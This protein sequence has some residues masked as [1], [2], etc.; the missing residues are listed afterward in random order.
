MA[1]ESASAPDG[2]EQSQLSALL[3]E[4]NRLNAA[5]LELFLRKC[6]SPRILPVL[7]HTMT[8]A[9]RMMR[10]KPYDILLLDLTLP[11][12]SG[13]ET[14]R[15]ARQGAPNA[16]IVVLTGLDDDNLASEAIKA[17]AQD[18]IAKGSDM[19]IV[20]RAIRY[21]AERSKAQAKLVEAERK[22]KT[23]QL[24]LIQAEKMES[25]GRLAAGVAHE[26]KNPLA[27]LQ[28]G[29]DLLC[30]LPLG[31]EVKAAEALRDMADAVT[32]AQRIINDL[33]DFSTPTALTKAPEKL[34]DIILLSLNLVK[35]EIK[36]RSLTLQ[37]ELSPSIPDLMLDRNAIQQVMV[38]LITNAAQA[39]PAGGRITVTTELKQFT[40][41]G[42][43][44]GRR[45]SDYYYV[46]QTV[47]VCRVEDTG[48]GIP[49]ELLNRVFDPFFTTKPQG[50]GTGLGLCVVRNIVELH[51]GCVELK[52]RPEG[53]ACAV[54]TF[55]P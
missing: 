19:S 25:V 54:V 23:A 35:H 42:G 9:E 7:A 43:L 16:A 48:P 2:A 4:D 29:L 50:E 11:D 15:R 27:I 17:G 47:V 20:V 52:N 41:A 3:V 14:V 21:A 26:V 34:N 44:V 33:L 1:T 46:G 45:A 38:N 18:Y 51:G 13:M 12:S 24:S 32:R 31:M 22:L 39:T 10:E 36:E 5:M 40:E 8:D 55:V 28:M 37:T 53:G 30:R 6:K 49:E